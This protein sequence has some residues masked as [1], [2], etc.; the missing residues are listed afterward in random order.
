MVPLVSSSV[1]DLAGEVTFCK[2]DAGTWE[3]LGERFEI[4]GFPT[5]VLFRD[6]QEI[7]REAGAYD[8]IGEFQAWIRETVAGEG[9]DDE[10]DEFGEDW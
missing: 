5:F 3:E 6:G 2:V 4:A 1:R 8:D 9:D 7:G 10:S